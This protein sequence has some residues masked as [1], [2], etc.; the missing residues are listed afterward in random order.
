M[1]LLQLWSGDVGRRPCP[2]GVSLV[3]VHRFLA[4]AWLSREGLKYVRLTDGSVSENEKKRETHLWNFYVDSTVSLEKH[5][6]AV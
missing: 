4:Q 3:V 1:S 6:T 2:H 5:L